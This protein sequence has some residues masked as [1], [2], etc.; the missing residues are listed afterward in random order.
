MFYLPNRST[1]YDLQSVC[2]SFLEGGR[3]EKHSL[4]SCPPKYKNT[5]TWILK[6][7]D[8][9]QSNI[10]WYWKQHENE[11]TESSLRLRLRTQKR[12]SIPRPFGRAMGCPLWVLCREYI[13]RYR[14]CTV[15]WA[16]RRRPTVTPTMP[17]PSGSELAESGD[18]FGIPAIA[19]LYGSTKDNTRQYTR[20]T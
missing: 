8:I 15:L 13:V 7:I 20:F 17:S 11:E 19:R 18:K 10:K 1:W 9:S 6:T 4:S 5:N 2:C 14:E 12:H 3:T 16:E